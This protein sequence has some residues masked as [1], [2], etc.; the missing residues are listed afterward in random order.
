MITR[1]LLLLFTITGY[2]IPFG[3]FFLNELYVPAI[4][5]FLLGVIWFVPNLREKGMLQ[6]LA[7][8]GGVLGNVMAI[9]LGFSDVIILMS[10]VLM[11]GTF[12]FTQF[13]GFLKRAGPCDETAIIETRYLLF[14]I[15]FFVVIFSISIITLRVHIETNFFQAILL[16][17][18]TFFGLIQLFR[19]LI[20][21]S[22]V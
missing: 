22:Q 1:L 6:G 20:D 14:S 16:V 12:E 19:W 15:V 10:T 8:S 3:F 2:G 9:W 18:L 7:L 11:L 17:I 13:L 5:L 21:R 4:F